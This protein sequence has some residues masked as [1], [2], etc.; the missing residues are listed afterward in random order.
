MSVDKHTYNY[1]HLLGRIVKFKT[2][3]GEARM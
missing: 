3:E 2:C 1:M